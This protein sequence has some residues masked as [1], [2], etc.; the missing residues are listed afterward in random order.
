MHNSTMPWHDIIEFHREIAVRSEESFFSFNVD[1]NNSER[2]SFIKPGIVNHML[3]ED[4][5]KSE[6]IYNQQILL[7]LDEKNT[8]FYIGGIFWFTNKRNYDGEWI[9]YANPLFYKP[10][11]IEKYSSNTYKLSPEQARWDISPM[12]Y[13]LLDKKGIVIEGDSEEIIKKIVES[14]EQNSEEGSF[15]DAFVKLLVNQFPELKKEFIINAPRQNGTNWI[16]FTAPKDYGAIMRMLILDYAKLLR[17]I[18]ADSSNYG[19]FSIFEETKVNRVEKQPVMPIVPLNESQLN[20]VEKVIS[21][22][23]VTVVT[24]PPG[25]GKSQVVLSILLNA[26]EKRQSVLFASSN[27]QA[28]DVVRNRIRPYEHSVDV[29]LVVR[30]GS[31]KMSEIVETFQ[32]MMAIMDDVQGSDL[33]VKSEEEIEQIRKDLD[34]LTAL[35]DSNLPQRID[36]QSRTALGAYGK[37]G[38]YRESYEIEIE[39]YNARLTELGVNCDINSFEEAVY[40]PVVQWKNEYNTL[41][42]EIRKVNDKRV[43]LNQKIE[44]I[45]GQIIDLLKG[46]YDNY[47]RGRKLTSKSLEELRLWYAEYKEFLLQFV[48]LDLKPV[49]WNSSFDAW[50]TSAETLK[51]IQ[52]AENAVDLLKKYIN[53]FGTDIDII[54]NAYARK[55]NTS[56]IIEE[57]DIKPLNDGSVETVKEWKKIYGAYVLKPKKALDILPFSEKSKM[58]K[59]MFELEALLTDFLGTAYLGIASDSVQR[60]TYISAHADEMLDAYNAQVEYLQLTDKIAKVQNALLNVNVSLEKL[61]IR[62][63]QNGLDKQEIEETKKAVEEK[64]SVASEANVAFQKKERR[65]EILEQDRKFKFRG[66]QLFYPLMDGLSERQEISRFFAYI[67]NNIYSELT[68]DALTE[69]RSVTYKHTVENYFETLSKS[70]SLW[71]EIDQVKDQIS[72]LKSEDLFKSEWKTKCPASVTNLFENLVYERT[73]DKLDQLANSLELIHNDWV[74]EGKSTIEKL[75]KSE[76]EEKEWA[77]SSIEKA[78]ELCP[79]NYLSETSDEIKK[80]IKAEVWEVSYIKGLFAKISSQG[81]SIRQASLKNKL[82]EALLN[83]A[84]SKRMSELRDDSNV[85]AAVSLL[86]SEYKNKGN[87]LEERYEDKFATALKALP[88]W[89]TTGQS[90]QAIPMAPGLFDILIIDEATQCTITAILPLIYRCKRIV[91]IGDP[92]QLPAIPNITASAERF[93]ADKYKL[94]QFMHF[95]GHAD[96]NIYKSVHELIPKKEGNV[97]FLSDHYRSHPLII[98]FA[99]NYVYKK[100]LVLKKPM[101][102][103]EDNRFSGVFGENVVGF[104]ERESRSDSWCNQKEAKSVVDLILRF[105]NIPE[106]SQY[107]IGVITP[108]RGQVNMISEMIAQHQEITNVL[109]ATVHKYQGDEKDI[110]IFSPVVSQ[111]MSAGAARW[112]ESPQNL[113]NVAITRAKEALYV[114]ADFAVCKQ[115]QGIL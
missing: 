45:Q 25:C 41:L 11:T 86:Y 84:V 42:D 5:L 88:L 12:F 20:V 59:Q 67:N 50:K 105:K 61:D 49:D 114:V 99:N 31:K 32:K 75:K 30:C 87:V 24:G 109:V 85:K 39:Q 16:A 111:G 28:V 62:V 23:P 22:N 64:I 52:D 96:C 10:F 90:P 47:S 65:N 14:A 40:A 76:Q 83:Q 9:R 93:L 72:G 81:L 74:G 17:K 97:M 27:N 77:C 37:A 112:V 7:T 94:E 115:Q 71:D 69:I 18:E 53:E 26:W 54:N 36:E 70:I 63:I 102:E 108:F 82:E 100:R 15:E 43:E 46:Y 6:S 101:K 106:Y 66:S 110:I 4:S 98:G 89:L 58:D 80:K 8:E 3:V 34:A 113:I 95:L 1:E 51:W 38:E 21:G 60:R 33:I 78:L 2:F 55:N 73:K 57:N 56:K 103:I 19:G 104:A 68:L 91:V 35:L 107:S 48:E 29:P 79:E 44:D 92:D 13:Q